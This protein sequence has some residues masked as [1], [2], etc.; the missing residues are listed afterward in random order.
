MSKKFIINCE[1]ATTICNK[2][3]YKEA[4]Y[5]EKIKL[6]IHLLICK[7]CGLYSAQNTTMTEIF[8]KHLHNHEEHNL[9]DKDK[10][11]LQHKL[12]EKIN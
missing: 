6:S 3:Q 9:S 1:E 5:W 11:R 4:S 10:E 2:N 8:E 7:K 12:E